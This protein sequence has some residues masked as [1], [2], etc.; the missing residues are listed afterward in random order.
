MV[1]V[2]RFLPAI[3][4]LVLFVGLTSVSA[5]SAAPLGRYLADDADRV[6]L[7]NGR[8][9]ALFHARG[10]IFGY[11]RRGKVR[12][13]DLPRGAE[14]RISVDGAETV[15]KINGQVTLY[16]G[17]R[18]S[19]YVEGG[20]WRVRLQ[21]HDIDAGAAVHGRLA[22]RG[23]DGT[24]SLRDRDAKDWPEHRQVFRLG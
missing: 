5:A 2:R 18:I 16:R 14:T 15:K 6:E 9:F 20:W 12:I 10:A 17:R 7:R 19:F 24:Y 4:G 3:C 8:G 21:G 11:I 22:L 1:N 23:R 13:A